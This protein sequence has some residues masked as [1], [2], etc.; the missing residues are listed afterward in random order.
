MEKHIYFF[1][2]NNL[3]ERMIINLKEG[4][5]SVIKNFY[6]LTLARLFSFVYFTKR[7]HET[8]L[9]CH[10]NCVGGMPE[11]KLP[12]MFGRPKKVYIYIE[13]VFLPGA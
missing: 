5:K 1:W 2:K 3:W 8:L 9:R 10:V 4:R 11:E 7:M 12:R 6:L 13:E